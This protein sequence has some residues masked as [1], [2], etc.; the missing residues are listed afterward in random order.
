MVDG[1]LVFESKAAKNS[2]SAPRMFVDSQEP[3]PHSS[4]MKMTFTLPDGLARQFQ[5]AYP[6]EK[7]SQV[8][9]GLLA[10]KLRAQDNQL[11]K[12]CRGANSL[13][14]VAKDMGDWEKLNL[15]DQ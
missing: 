15:H 14:Q 2:D 7:Q 11:A 9:A 4:T 3:Q 13:K 10:K 5:S 8:V 12:A 6:Q 1:K